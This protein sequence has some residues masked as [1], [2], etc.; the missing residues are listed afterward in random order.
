MTS[1]YLEM[2]VWE[3]LAVTPAQLQELTPGEYRAL[4]EYEVLRQHEEARVA[5][6]AGSSLIGLLSRM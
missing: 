4:I 6:G 2:R 1:K 3:R 5:S